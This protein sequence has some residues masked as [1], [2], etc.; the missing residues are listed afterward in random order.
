MCDF[1]N[2]EYLAN[3]TCNYINALL[4]EK[5]VDMHFDIKDL[6]DE[7]GTKKEG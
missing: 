6:Q 3:V 2:D 7:S 1:N 5:G 4:K